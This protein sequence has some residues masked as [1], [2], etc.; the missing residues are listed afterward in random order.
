MRHEN[1]FSKYETRFWTRLLLKCAALSTYDFSQENHVGMLVMTN[2]LNF[3]SSI[4]AYC[5]R[6]SFHI[7]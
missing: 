6:A 3:G 1:A 7:L 5:I 4:N 2:Q